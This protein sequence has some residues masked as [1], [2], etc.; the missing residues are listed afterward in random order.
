VLKEGCSLGANCTILPGLSIGRWA[1][2][3]AGAVVT[4]NIPDFGLAVGVPGRLRGWVC[5]C[6]KKLSAI[7]NSRWVC[8][9]SRQYEQIAEKVLREFPITNGFKRHRIPR[10]PKIISDLRFQ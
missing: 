8:S 5:R 3:G 1:M 6:G 9:C 7:N 2:I 4:R 10:S